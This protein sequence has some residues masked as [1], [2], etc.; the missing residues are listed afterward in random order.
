LEAK[1]SLKQEYLNRKARDTLSPDRP[2]RLDFQSLTLFNKFEM[3]AFMLLSVI[4]IG[5]F[6]LATTFVQ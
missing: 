2:V 3:T 6:D 5:L 4:S 1:R